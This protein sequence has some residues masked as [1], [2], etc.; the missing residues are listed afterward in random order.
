[1]PFQ[2]SNHARCTALEEGGPRPECLCGGASTLDALLLGAT[3]RG[4]ESTNPLP[5]RQTTGSPCLLFL[6]CLAGFAHMGVDRPLP[7]PL[8]LS[9]QR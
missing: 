1:M 6:T 5:E 7:V 4:R 3:D 2:I 8:F 9:Y